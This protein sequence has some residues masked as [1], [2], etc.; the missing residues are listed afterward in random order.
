MR[1]LFVPLVATLVVACS[2]AAVAQS[3][4]REGAR[5]RITERGSH[6]ISGVVQ[7]STADSIVLYA[8]PNG[9]K[10]SF[11]R[12]RIE[13]MQTSEG[14]SAS[15]GAVKGGLWGA[16]VMAA[17]GGLV[18][19]MTANEDNFEQVYGEGQGR[20]AYFGTSVLA[21]AMFGAA[22]GAVLRSERWQEVSV[23]PV[24]GVRSAGMRVSFSVR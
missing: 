4:V 1:K 21:G 24:V 5:V 10:M 7:S 8:E 15:K 18:L 9:A 16:G 3:T 12:S 13:S 19:A 14:K 2:S 20:G 23:Q 6:R 11:A 22:I 17:G